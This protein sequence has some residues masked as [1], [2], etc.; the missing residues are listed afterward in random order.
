MPAHVH[1]P[2]ARRRR[3]PLSGSALRAVAQP[4]NNER[5][6]GRS[7]AV[8]VSS[9]NSSALMSSAA[10]IAAKGMM[11]IV[12]PS[13]QGQSGDGRESMTLGGAYRCI[14]RAAAT[15]H[16]RRDGFAG[17]GANASNGRACEIRTRRCRRRRGPARESINISLWC[18]R[19]NAL[20]Q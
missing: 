11:V 4:P 20:E 13:R 14:A 1:G 9:K 18:R 12:R 19:R 15:A 3:L 7:L 16:F 5:V 6:V 2:S 8:V 17:I 10:L